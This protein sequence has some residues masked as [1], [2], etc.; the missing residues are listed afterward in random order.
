[1]A[2]SAAA[3]GVRHLLIRAMKQPIAV[4]SIADEAMPIVSEIGTHP[5]RQRSSHE[6]ANEQ[7][8]SNDEDR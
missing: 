8:W 5:A 3:E 7:S 4:A 2:A 1:L 6:V